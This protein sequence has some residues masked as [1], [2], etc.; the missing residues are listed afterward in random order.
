NHINDA[1]TP[2]SLR[3]TRFNAPYGHD[4]RFASLRDFTRNVIVNEF[5]GPEPSGAILDALVAYMQD[6]ALLPNPRL[7]PGGGLR[8]TASA[9]AQRG[10]TLFRRPFPGNP[11][12]SCAGC[13]V[14]SGLFSDHLQHDIGTGLYKTPTL[15]NAN[16]NAPYFHDGRFDDYRQVVAY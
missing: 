8:A 5:D 3:G 11:A 15:R 9:A 6:I 14:P 12:L 4:G 10:E 1:L 7:A 13:H 16:F 2:P